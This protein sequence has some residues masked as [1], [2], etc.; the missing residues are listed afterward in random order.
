[1][2]TARREDLPEHVTISTAEIMEAAAAFLAFGDVVRRLAGTD[3]SPLAD[4]IGAPAFRL[5]VAAGL[6]NE[7]G[8]DVR[9]LSA[10]DAD[11]IIEALGAAELRYTARILERLAATPLPRPRAA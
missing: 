5:L 8:A 7:D 1:V 4:D 9:G 3:E 6:V 10:D 2:T 11:G